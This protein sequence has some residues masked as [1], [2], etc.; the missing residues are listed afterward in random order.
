MASSSTSSTSSTSLL[1]TLNAALEKCPKISKRFQEV[2][3]PHRQTKLR[4]PTTG[5]SY[6]S[7][8]IIKKIGIE[9]DNTYSK[10]QLEKC[11]KSHT[12]FSLVE[13]E[14]Y[15]YFEESPQTKTSGKTAS[16]IYK[17]MMMRTSGQQ[18]GGASS[19]G[20]SASEGAP[21]K[22]SRNS[23]RMSQGGASS[24]GGSAADMYRLIGTPEAAWKE[25]KK[26]KQQTLKMLN[27]T[28]KLHGKSERFE[29]IEIDV[30]SKKAHIPPSVKKVLG[31]H[32]PEGSTTTIREVRQMFPDRKFVVKGRTVYINE[33]L[34]T[35]G[36]GATTG[37]GVQQ[38]KTPPP[39]Q[40]KKVKQQQQQYDSDKPPS[41]YGGPD[42]DYFG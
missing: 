12:P 27:N 28:M 37:A 40:V 18:G 3:I 30:P 5:G 9:K 35:H 33:D 24:G 21:L 32:L 2:R 38:K 29:I 19:G 1:Q 31:Y 15:Y 13:E 7:T 17:K 16:E 8:K 39:K 20:E 6:A 10:I 26:Q 22:V 36:G 23:P 34:P 42:F 41:D 4:N 14:K 11:L 25:I